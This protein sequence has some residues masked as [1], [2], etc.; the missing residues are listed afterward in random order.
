MNAW[1]DDGDVRVLHGDCI[2]QMKLL[3]AESID[4]VICDPPYGLEFMG[5]DWDS[6][7]PSNSRIRTRVDG[8][9]NGATKSTVQTPEAYVAGT[10]FQA[11]C[12]AWAREAYRVL[13]PGGHLAAFGGTRTSHRLAAGIE[14]AGFEIRDTL[15]WLYGSGFPKSLDVSKAI[16]KAAGAERE[17]VGDAIRPDGRSMQGARGNGS[18]ASTQ[19]ASNGGEPGGYNY[20]AAPPST[21]P[22]TPDAELWQGWGTALKPAHEPIT[23]ARK[24]LRGTVAANVLAFGTGALNIDATRIGHASDADLAESLA[25]NPGR[26]DLVTSDVYGAGRGQQSVNTAGRWP[27][28]VILGHSPDCKRVGTKRVKGSGQILD[29]HRRSTLGGNG[30]THGAMRGVTGSDHVDADGLETVEAWECAAD[31]AAAILDQQTGERP[32]GAVH[33]Y[34]RTSS[35][36]FPVGQ[37]MTYTQDAST[38]GA[39]RF[40]YTAKA[41][42]S[43]RNDGLHDLPASGMSS[44]GYGSIQTPKLD[45]ATPRENWTPR[46]VRNSHPTVKPVDLMRWLIRLLAPPGALILDPF[47]G[48]GTTGVAARAEQV[49]C[50]L[51]EREA[52]YLPIIAGRLSQLSLFSDA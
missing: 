18:R 25:K 6:F 30:Q 46:P 29:H 5:K 20:A 40:F 3:P 16:D 8:R 49:R 34:E 24:P 50:V 35:P 45:R 17:I 39:S 22:A 33:P 14:D 36:M 31:C 28:N 42:S 41:S 11:W 15:A 7:K 37:S 27:A 23:L 2:E 21:A 13:K 38:G 51:I 1:L 32:T 10:A 26:D 4:A 19:G 48:S 9:T 47:A 52:E 43:E 12:E 44:D